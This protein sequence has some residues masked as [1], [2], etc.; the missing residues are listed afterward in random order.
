VTRRCRGCGMV[1]YQQGNVLRA[2]MRFHW[3]VQWH[4]VLAVLRG[5]RPQQRAERRR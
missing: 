5:R 4:Q 3:H 1:V 2:A